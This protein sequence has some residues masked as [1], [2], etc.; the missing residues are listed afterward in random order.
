MPLGSPV[1]LRPSPARRMMANMAAHF[2]AASAIVVALVDLGSGR[3]GL[4]PDV[5]ADGV[6]VSLG[7]G[8][9]AIDSDTGADEGLTIRFSAVSGR[10]FLHSA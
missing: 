3:W 9:Y 2:A 10:A 8:R 4:E 5:S 6:V 7:S 1:V